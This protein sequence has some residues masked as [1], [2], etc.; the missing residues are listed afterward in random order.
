MRAVTIRRHGG[1]SVVRFETLPDPQPGPGEVLVRL[2]A[3]ALNHLD[4]WV[5]RGIPGLKLAFPHVMGSDGAG[6]V[7]STGPD[8]DDVSCGDRVLIDPGISCGRCEFCARGD[9]SLC[10]SFHLLGEHV[11][12]TWAEFVKV[13]RENVH[14]IP[15]HL[16]FREA[17]ALPLVFLTA[18]R[19]LFTRG[20]L[21]AG[22]DL[23]VIGVGGGVAGAALRLGLAAG[24]RVIVTSGS[25]RKLARATRLGAHHT[26]NHARKDFLKEVR[27]ITDGRG[28]DVCAD[29]V[30][31]A[32]WARSLKCLAK[33]GRLVTCG[34]TTGALP[35]TDVRR[36]FWNQ[37]SILGS[38]MGSRTDFRNMLRFVRNRRIRPVVDSAFPLEEARRAVARMEKGEQFGKIVLRIRG[39]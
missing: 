23:L 8:V 19:M 5:R 13:P 6:T 25:P 12:G 27:R 15:P 20:R 16:S 18:W 10:V 36:I 31:E 21:R 26:I 38:T 22:E 30:G 34:A 1:P 24:A 35:E 11:H 3:A 9:H 29:S 37:L 7:A 2:H 39:R 14:P 28:V 33:G 17:A 4:I 32:T